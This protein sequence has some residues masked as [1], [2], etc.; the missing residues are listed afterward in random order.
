MNM[1]SALI[2]GYLGLTELPISGEFTLEKRGWSFVKTACDG[3]IS[4]IKIKGSTK[5]I[6]RKASENKELIQ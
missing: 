4:S 1:S 2:L 3:M 5:Q 6:I